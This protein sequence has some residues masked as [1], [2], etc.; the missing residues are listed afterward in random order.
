M[1]TTTDASTVNGDAQLEDFV[2]LSLLDQIVSRF[3]QAWLICVVVVRSMNGRFRKGS[4]I[5]RRYFG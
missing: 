2:D 3:P 1:I 4:G 5:H